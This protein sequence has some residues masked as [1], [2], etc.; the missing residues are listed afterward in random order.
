M[1]TI[2]KYPNRRLYD[3]EQSRYITLVDLQQLVM[4][5]DAFQVIDANTGKDLH[6]QYPSA[7]HRRAGEWR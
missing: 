1:R 6:P 7:D 2:K 5:G 3:T 4:E